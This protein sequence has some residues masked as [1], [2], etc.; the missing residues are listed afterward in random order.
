V[1]N[2]FEKILSLPVGFLTEHFNRF[3]GDRTERQIDNE[4]FKLRRN[5]IVQAK[6]EDLVLRVKAFDEE[7]HSVQNTYE[8]I[9]AQQLKMARHVDE[10]K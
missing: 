5:M 1:S 2:F 10:R 9:V 3:V 8:D 6:L 7:L 4:Y